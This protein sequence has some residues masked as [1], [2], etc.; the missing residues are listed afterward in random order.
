MKNWKFKIVIL[1]MLISILGTGIASASLVQGHQAS[2]NKILIEPD[3]LVQGQVNKHGTLWIVSYQTP[4]GNQ[5]PHPFDSLHANNLTLT[6]YSPISKVTKASIEVKSFIKSTNTTEYENQSF[7]VLP[8]E[9]EEFDLLIPSSTHKQE[10]SITYNNNT[11]TYFIQTYSPIKFPFGNSPLGM[12]AMIGIFMLIATGLNIGVTQ[13]I[14]RRAKY[15]PKL[16]QRAWIGIIVIT[17]LII[18]NITTQY[19][20]D[21]TGKDWAIWLLPLWFFDLLMILSSWKGKDTDNI[22]IHL[23]GS[24]DKEIETGI[25]TIKTAPLDAKEQTKIPTLIQSG[26]EYIDTRSYVDFIKRLAGKHI[27]VT[28]DVAE[29]PD[30]LSKVSSRFPE[31]KDGIHQKRILQWHFKDRPNKEQP[32]EE[33]YLIDP[34]SPAPIIEKIAIPEEPQQG[35]Q[36]EKRWHRKKYVTILQSRLN[37][38]HMQEAEYFLNNYITASESGKEIHRLNKELAQNQSELNTRAYKF[39]SEIIDH[40]FDLSHKRSAYRNFKALPEKEKEGDETDEQ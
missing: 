24:S 33:G 40:I 23:K 9:V 22:L 2:S 14:L 27:Y 10:I 13:V 11:V 28:W 39:Q 8:R 12:L 1:I 31:R 16:S 4:T 18:Y 38:K 32:F 37:G 6:I 17:G 26:M 35:E 30:K 21:M 7:T 19:Y 25:Y 34:K 5:Y 20:Y 3:N 29:N 36:K 15:F